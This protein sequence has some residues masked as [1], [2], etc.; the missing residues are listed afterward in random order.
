MHEECIVSACLYVMLGPGFSGQ[1][2]TRWPSP[3]V[4][5]N[6]WHSAELSACPRNW[7]TR[8]NH[9][10]LTGCVALYSSHQC[11]FTCWVSTGNCAWM[12]ESRGWWE[13]CLMFARI[14]SRY[15]GLVST[16]SASSSFSSSLAPS[17][18]SCQHV[19][20]RYLHSIDLSMPCCCF[21][22]RVAEPGGISVS[23]GLTSTDH[24]CLICSVFHLSVDMICSCCPASCSLSVHVDCIQYHWELFLSEQ[25]LMKQF[26][27]WLNESCVFWY[28][29]VLFVSCW[30]KCNNLSL[31]F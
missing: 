8:S 17:F 15:T 30:P 23:I 7:N 16:L 29:V 24:T 20:Y 21:P 26:Y 13:W 4:H 18:A 11:L 28:I 5:R 22:S 3:V 12:N 1:E 27:H 9:W 2:F 25:C 10:F 6:H 19:S 31:P 14:P